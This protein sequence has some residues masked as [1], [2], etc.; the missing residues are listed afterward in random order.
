MVLAH[1]T[2][3]EK[4]DFVVLHNGDGY[5]NINSGVPTLCIPSLTMQDGPNGLSAG[6]TG[7]TALP[8]SLGIAASFDL[9]L[10]YDYG[11]V[12]GQ[13]AR[14]KGIDAVQGPN[15]NLLRVP[16]SGRAFEGY[17]EDPVMVA[18]MGVAAIEGIQS[19]GVMADAKH[20]T[21]YNQE[22]ARTV[23]NQRISPRVLQEL[24]LAPFKAAVERAHVAS[25]MCAY[26][27]LNDVNI[28]SDPPLYAALRSW[29]FAG[30]VRS[31]L[32]AVKSPDAAFKAGLDLIKPDTPSSIVEMVSKGHLPAALLTEAV[33]RVL[34]EMFRFHLIGTAPRGTAGNK[35]TTKNHAD[36]ALLAA[37]RSIVLLKNAG[38]VLPLSA[39]NSGSIAVIGTDSSSAAVSEGEGGAHVQGPFLVKP[40]TAIEHTVGQ[41]NIAYAPGAPVT[42]HLPLIPASYF[43]SGSPLPFIAPPVHHHLD[44]GRS[45]LGIIRSTGVTEEIATADYP[46]ST[47]SAWTTWKATIVPPKTGLYELSLGENGDTWLSIN[48]STVMAFRGLHGRVTWTTTVSLIGGRSYNFELDWF[49]T[50]RSNPRLG[51]EYVTPLIDQAVTAARHAHTAIVFVSDFSSEGFDR[52]DLSLPGDA[53]AL[54]EAVSAA[55]HR[56]IVVLNTGGAVLMPWLKSVQAVLEAWYP[57]EEAGAATDAVL[58]GAV[59]PSA[60]LPITF[61]VSNTQVPTATPSRWPGVDGTVDYSEG[62]DIGYRYLET[63]H[64]Q[65]LFA[66]G[67]GLTYTSFRLSAPSVEVSRD[68]DTIAV[69]V[70]NTG[71]RSGTDVIECYLEFPSSAGE[72]P[73]QLRGFVNAELRPGRS[74]TV[75]LLLARSAFEDF[76]NGHFSV[77]TGS[78]TA[79]VGS[80]SESFSAR[81]PIQAPTGSVA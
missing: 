40:L 34:I 12:L 58:F 71:K 78:F 63:Q 37:E 19:Q 4:A 32:E 67:Y 79:F 57:G 17:G 28:C 52:P 13:E 54:I 73:L 44:L 72:P 15:L 14:G 62:L 61:P 23:L 21:A 43:R 33:R 29:N 69:R 75:H 1:M 3:A 76:Q 70:S 48:G 38:S 41:R 5:E 8:S 31:D 77:P 22:T 25:I 35:V 47:G 18:A 55:N 80:S 65:P 10:A 81:V 49:R 7:V 20:L 2:L 66:F 30:F 64:L 53:D 50:N 9:G 27:A 46:V 11:R 36:F 68:H 6:I 56:T 60:R 45:D 51:W 59:D 42:P 16:E 24:Y 26:G 39:S 74:K